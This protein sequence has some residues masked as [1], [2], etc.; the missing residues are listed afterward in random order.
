MKHPLHI[1]VATHSVRWGAIDYALTDWRKDG[2]A[3]TATLTPDG[4]SP[5]A[6]RIEPAAEALTVDGIAFHLI[7]W[8]T[9]GKQAWAETEDVGPGDAWFVAYS[10]RLAGRVSG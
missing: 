10:E 1:D 6:L 4:W 9:E 8:R 7:G 3:Y 5:S 2:A